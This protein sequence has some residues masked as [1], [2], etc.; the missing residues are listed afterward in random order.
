MALPSPVRS[1]RA[2]LPPPFHILE[3]CAHKAV[4]I[5][6]AILGDELARQLRL[7]LLPQRQHFL[8][9]ISVYVFHRH[10]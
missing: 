4:Y 7:Q 6:L 1:V 3:G 5:V 9:A 10:L 2:S 8:C